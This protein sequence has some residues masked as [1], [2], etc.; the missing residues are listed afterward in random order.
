MNLFQPPL[1][2]NVG[3]V[4]QTEGIKYA[5]SKLK[6]LSHILELVGTVRPTTILDGFAGTTRVTQALAGAGYTVYANDLA[7]WSKVFAT[8][9]LLNE[10][11]RRYYQELIDS[12]NA[13]DGKHGWFSENYG[14]HP[15][16]GTAVQDD[17]LKKP[18]QYHVTYKLD[19]IREHIE[20]L[21]LNEIEKSVVLTSLILA[22]DKVDNT[23]GHYAS[24]L[25][26]WSP[27]SYNPLILKV[28]TIRPRNRSHRVLNEDVFDAIN[29]TSVD[30]AYFDPPYGSNNEKMPPSRVRYA[31]YYHIWKTVCLNDKPA[32]FGKAR[33]RTDSSDKA[34]PNKFED[35]RHNP[36]TG[37]FIAVEAIE[38]LIKEVDAEYV[39]LSYSS[40]GRATANELHE[41]LKSHGTI[42]RIAKVDY[43]KN[44]MAD[45]KW[46]NEWTREAGEPHREFLFLI[47][48]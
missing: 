13:L 14:G 27:R 34:R 17:G 22:L 1:F 32:L 29:Q 24:Y 7:I 9:Y 19:A 37:K 40:G 25:K 4:I 15:N 20:S 18:W 30:L 5:G 2:G 12:L 39:L 35:F 43:K 8:N 41:I 38:R 36:H 6:L 48:K 47:K 44:V 28:P 11:P 21:N 26:K 42:L 46:T 10:H 45:M 23:I 16:E 3:S 33:R 31:A